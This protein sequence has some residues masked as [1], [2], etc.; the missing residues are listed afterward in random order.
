MLEFVLTI[1][2]GIVMIVMGIA[3]IKGNISF[4]HSYHRNNVAPQDVLPFGKMVG[5]G[6]IIC[7]ISLIVM[8]CLSICAIVC[9]KEIL[10]LIG[11]VML[12]LGLLIGLI[13]TFYAIK[14]YNKGIF[15]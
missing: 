12:I 14:K 10:A 4:L 15:G 1:I 2:I 13:I 9:E 5:I 8:G 6:T 11:T 3:N 7:G